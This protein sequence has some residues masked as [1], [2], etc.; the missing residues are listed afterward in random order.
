MKLLIVRRHGDEGDVDHLLV[1]GRDRGDCG[2]G[3]FLGSSLANR[4]SF[5]EAAEGSE[6]EG[7]FLPGFGDV[8]DERAQD[9]CRD[10]AVATGKGSVCLQ[11]LLN[12]FVGGELA[13]ALGEFPA[14]LDREK[15]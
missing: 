4:H 2:W 6:V 10:V 3:W 1:A 12:P 14:V 8:D 13:Q 9:L 15:P 7:V 5:V 11:F